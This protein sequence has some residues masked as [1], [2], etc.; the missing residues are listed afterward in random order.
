M[1]FFENETAEW[2]VGMQLCTALEKMPVEDASIQWPEDLSP[3]V[4]AARIVAY[5]ASTDF[6]HSADGREM[7]GPRSIDELRD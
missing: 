5:N 3:Y 4:P 6:R 1:K 7:V 2:N